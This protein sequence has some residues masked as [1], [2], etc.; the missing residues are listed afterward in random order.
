MVRVGEQSG[1][2]VGIGRV[3]VAA[4][5]TVAIHQD[6]PRAMDRTSAP[7]SAAA[8]LNPSSRQ[9]VDHAFVAG[10]EMPAAGLRIQARG[11]IPQDCGSVMF[12]IDA[13]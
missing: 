10:Q 1:Y 13:E 3:I 8:S 4:N 11:I 2:G 7:F 5:H 6:H 9:A 12:R